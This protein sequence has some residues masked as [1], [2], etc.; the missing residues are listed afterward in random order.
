MIKHLAFAVLALALW[1]SA[2]LAEGP[3]AIGYLGLH[4]DPL[5]H[6]DIVYTRIE[7]APGGNPI[8]GATMGVSDLKVVSDAVGQTVSLDHQQAADAT[9]LAAKVQAMV[10]AGEH[11]II[12]DLPAELVEQV[13]TATKDLPATLINATAPE[14]RLRSLCLPNL[15][16]TAASD[17]MNAD[18]MVQYLRTRNWTKVLM[19]VGP[20]ER[21]KAMADAF[22]ASADRQRINFV[23]TLTF[24][25][26][27]DPANRESNNSQLI[28][29]NADYDVVYVAD[30]QGEFSRYLPYDTQLPRLVIGSTGLAA[31]EWQ[32]SWDRDGSTQV[33]VRFEELTK[34]RRMTGQ[35]WATW[36]AA[37][38][39]VTAYAKARSDDY[40][41]IAEYIRGSRLRMDG[42]KGVQLNFRPWDG[43]MR[44]PIVLATHNAVIAEAPLAGFLHQTNTLD[45]LGTD[46]PEQQCL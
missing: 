12:L 11:F 4:D 27:T 41:K 6:P 24:T 5:Y 2:A 37:K 35:D 15:L 40:A 36:I 33:T 44:M 42:A 9:S 43:Q 8:D 26:A 20:L 3:V 17:R 25:L 22:R 34:G 23:D 46:E 13:A 28:T 10:T 39:I 7:M 32:W 16:H 21:D 31:S 29:G 45:T 14:D 18:A 1:S 19:L 30:N 38:S